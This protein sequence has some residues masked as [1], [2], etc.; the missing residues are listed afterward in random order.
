MITTKI[1]GQTGITTASVLAIT[2]IVSIPVCTGTT[3][4]SQDGCPP[5]VTI[6]GS[7]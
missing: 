1:G 5:S 6:V 7:Y 3:A 2:T 4:F